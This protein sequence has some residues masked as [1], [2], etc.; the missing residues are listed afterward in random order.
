MMLRYFTYPRTHFLFIFRFSDLFSFNLPRC[1]MRFNRLDFNSEV[2][3]FFN[4]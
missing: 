2:F 4:V 1:C 3:D